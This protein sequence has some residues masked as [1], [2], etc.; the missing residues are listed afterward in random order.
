MYVYIY[1]RVG[2]YVY[3]YILGGFP[4]S[5]GSAVPISSCSPDGVSC[6][7]SYHGVFLHNSNQSSLLYNC[8]A[9][10]RSIGLSLLLLRWLIVVK[11]TRQVMN[12][13]MFACPCYSITNVWNNLIELNFQKLLAQYVGNVL[14][15]LF[16]SLKFMKDFYLRMF[17]LSQPSFW[18]VEVLFIAGL[19]TRKTVVDLKK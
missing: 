8:I 13:C 1:I 17:P 19:A 9:L 5:H 16:F 4:S 7:H 10:Y 2:M 6:K 3:P 12:C 11:E 15:W 14:M 18:A